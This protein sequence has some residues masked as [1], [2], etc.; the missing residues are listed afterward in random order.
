MG[1][2]K[3]D[4]SLSFAD[5]ALKSSLKH[6]RS[7]K[8][9][10]KLNKAINWSRIESI[11]MIHYTIG[12]S[13]EGADA[14]HPLLLF[15]C[16]L[17]QKWFRINSDP[18]L[19]NQIN[20][21]LSFKKFLGISFSKPSPD[22]STFSRF[23]KRLSK[24]AMDQINSEILRQ[25]ESQG[26]T[27]NEGIAVDARLVK[28]TSRPISNNQIKELRDKRKTPESKLDKNGKPLKFSRDLDSDWVIQN[29]KPHYGLKEH[30][31]V[32]INHGFILAT[33]LTPSS[34]NDTNCLSYCTIYSRHTKQPI[35]KGYAGKP[36]RDFLAL[37][38]IADGIMRKDSTTAK[39]TSYEKERNKKISRVP[40]IVEQ[41]FGLSHLHDGAKRARFP[42]IVKNKF[43]CW[44]RQ[45]A[46]NI[47]R[48]LK[49]LGVAT[50]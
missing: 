25:F 9:M 28:S 14:Y 29:D 39:L 37:N 43:D 27:I 1:F 19:E 20:D 5:L 7:L 11:L 18:E 49:I 48:G 8:T 4:Q 30:A 34:V 13:K 15:K 10:E 47:S 3:M 22:H 24:N 45:S 2:K 32:D 31:S 50:V 12:T 26:L 46:Y 36:N 42:D 17:L 23:R 21:R 16:L 40:Y 35:E 6:N 44:Y 33:T 41:Y 38:N